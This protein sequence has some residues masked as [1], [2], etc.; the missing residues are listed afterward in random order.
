[1]GMGVVDLTMHVRNNESE[2]AVVVH[3]CVYSIL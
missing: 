1:M 2:V 3:L